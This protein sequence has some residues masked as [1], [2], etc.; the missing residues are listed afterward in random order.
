MTVLRA[1]L[2][3]VAVVAFIATTTAIL[4]T[5]GSTLGYDYQA[6]VGAAQR[7]LDGQPLYDESVAVAG[8]FAIFLYP[9]PFALA[10]IPFAL[11]PDQLGLWLWEALAV[12]AF[13]AGVATLPVRAPVR[14]GILLLGALDWPLLFAFKLGQVGPLLFLLFAI[15]WRW[16]DR[17][18]VLGL[19]MAA[20]AMVK[21]QP[22]IL[23]AWAG[24]TGRWRAVG[25]AL[26][27]LAIAALVSTVVLGSGVWGEYAAL[28]SRVSSPVTTPHNF[29][30]GAIAYQAGVAQ[31][32]AELIQAVTLVAVLAVVLIAI[33]TASDEVSYLT[34]VVASQVL[35]PLLWDHYAVV[36]LLPT[37]W[38]L[39]RGQWW[40]VAIPLL[41]SLPLVSIAPP[42]VYPLVFGLGL[43]GPLAVDLA[44]RRRSLTAARRVPAGST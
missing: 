14:W 37:A 33:R 22:L 32:T 24:L 4:A 19:S 26:A 27:T 13:V 6:Y 31:S 21:L 23:L 18:G 20:G 28:L 12:A 2:P 7:A 30:P 8:G 44:E 17:A 29:T 3:I 15:G 1:A 34:A 11:A 10:L 35:S 38:L 36:L 39:A 40:A 16:R 9:P 5:A 42:V 41:T 25:V 43:L